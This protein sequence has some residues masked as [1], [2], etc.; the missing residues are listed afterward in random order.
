M[1]GYFKNKK[2]TRTGCSSLPLYFWHATLTLLEWSIHSMY[3][4]ALISTHNLTSNHVRLR[5]WSLYFPPPSSSTFAQLLP[6][7][8]TM[9]AYAVNKHKSLRSASELVLRWSGN[10]LIHQFLHPRLRGAGAC[11]GSWKHRPEFGWWFLSALWTF[12]LAVGSGDAVVAFCDFVDGE[13]HW[14]WRESGSVGEKWLEWLC[15]GQRGQSLIDRKSRV[16]LGLRYHH[17]GPWRDWEPSISYWKAPLPPYHL[18]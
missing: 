11:S 12:A 10:V 16:G 7:L 17:F 9:R 18:H 14:S 13:G 4:S 5:T 8:D 15:P 2:F 3:F 6:R 1:D